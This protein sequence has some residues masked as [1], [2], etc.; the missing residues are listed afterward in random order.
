MDRRDLRRADHGEHGQAEPSGTIAARTAR[1]RHA[2]FVTVAN[3][4]A[5]ARPIPNTTPMSTARS[6]RLKPAKRR[7]DVQERQ[8]RAENEKRH[9]DER[10]HD[11]EA[12]HASSLLA[13][14]CTV[15]QARLRRSGPRDPRPPARARHQLTRTRTPHARPSASGTTRAAP[16]PRADG[17]VLVVEAVGGWLTG[18]VALIADAGHMLTDAGALGIALFAAWAASRPRRPATQLRLRSR[19]DPGGAPERAP[20]RRCLGR[21]RGRIVLA[22]RPP[23][24][25]CM[26]APCSASRRSASRRT[27]SRGCSC[28]AARAPT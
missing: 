10:R 15:R 22:P 27:W 11:P 24:T 5:A 4:D 20:A 21:D 18:S 28:C 8:Q 25:R 1:G 3:A 16:R 6:T 2:L 14:D 26:R 13:R 7:Q 9:D 23:R 17:A 19:R 12:F